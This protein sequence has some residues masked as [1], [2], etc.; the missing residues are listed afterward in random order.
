M[1]S[2]KKRFVARDLARA[3]GR[4]LRPVR[5]ALHLAAGVSFCSLLGLSCGGSPHHAFAFSVPDG[6]VRLHEVESAGASPVGDGGIVAPDKGEQGTAGPLRAVNPRSRP[7][8]RENM[9]VLILPQSATFTRGD[10]DRV[11]QELS[12]LIS[13]AMGNTPVTVKEDH[14]QFVQGVG[15]ANVIFDFALQ[16]TPIRE[17]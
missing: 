13:K 16:G 15:C 3:A 17:A 6:W 11:A 14:I 5:A 9:N 10:V 12:G 4:P 1:W 8:F 7:D 2:F